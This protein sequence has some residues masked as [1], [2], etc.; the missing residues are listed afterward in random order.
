M[1][2]VN[3]K[4]PSKEHLDVLAIY[5]DLGNVLRVITKFYN[6]GEMYGLGFS[7]PKS[8]LVYKHVD[9]NSVTKWVDDQMKEYPSKDCRFKSNHPELYKGEEVA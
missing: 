3:P 1:A 6:D 2:N 9:D 4:I 8:C 5:A 7:I